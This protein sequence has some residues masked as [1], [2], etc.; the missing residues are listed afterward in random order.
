MGDNNMCKEPNTKWEICV[1]LKNTACPYLWFP[2]GKNYQG[3]L[4]PDRGWKTAECRDENECP[5]KITIECTHKK[6]KE[7]KG[8]D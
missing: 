2:K 5:I 4:H 8:R 7:T 1:V 6:K 3:C